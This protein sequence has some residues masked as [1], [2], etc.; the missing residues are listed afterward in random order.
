MWITWCPV[1]DM[2]VVFAM[3]DKKAKHKGMSVFVMDMDSPRCIDQ[4]H[5]GET[6]DLGLPYR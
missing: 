1:A 4:G 5:Q 2:A 3:T 6:G